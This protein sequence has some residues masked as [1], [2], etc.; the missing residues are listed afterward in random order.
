MASPNPLLQNIQ[1]GFR[2]LGSIIDRVLGQNG[3]FSY[4]TLL[5]SVVVLVLTTRFFTGWTSKSKS[6]SDGAPQ[7][8]PSLP[9]WVP[10]LGHLVNLLLS[11]DSLLKG[12]RDTSTRGIFALNLGGSTHNVI[13]SPSLSHSLLTQKSNVASH[14]PVAW[15]IL[16]R[17]FGM[18]LRQKPAYEELQP[19]L[20]ATINDHLLRD[21]YLAEM[22]NITMGNLRQNIPNLVSFVDSLVDQLPWER[23][24]N[25]TSI[26]NE[27]SGQYVEASLTPLLK[28][29][30]AHTA[31]P[32]LF[33]RAFVDNYPQLFDWL[34]AFDAGFLL[35]S[36]G[37]PRFIPYPGLTRAQIARSRLLDAM[38][39]FHRALDAYDTGKPA[40]DS[41]W[42]DMSDVS[43]LVR[44]R[45]AVYRKYNFPPY[46][47]AASDLALLWAMNANANPL[48]F[49]LVLRVYQDRDLLS[50]IQQEVA[51]YVRATQRPA[52]FGIPE[53]PEVTI[54][55]PGLTSKCP[56]LKACYIESLRVDSAPWSLKKVLQDFNLAESKADAGGSD[57]VTYRLKKGE[58]ADVAFD[59]HFT[60]PKFFPEPLEW[61]PDRHLKDLDGEG[62]YV[63]P[64]MGTIRPYGGGRGMCKGRVFAEK[65]CFAYAAAIFV[66]W[67]IEP[68][69]GERELKI[70]RH[71]KAT[72]VS[73]P[74]DDVR[75]RL[76]RREVGAKE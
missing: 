16:R 57:P 4:T 49:W 30:V 70:P 51:P 19:E 27:S 54:D 29:F 20:T 56:L 2:Y 37:A 71:G 66:L 53:P 55:V 72:A 24:S 48:I 62:R 23:V 60:D 22:V 69:G 21:P 9:Y 42:S 75:V 32:S 1:D 65:E 50:R 76:R 31:N 11:P 18:P 58:Y 39:S 7:Y 41:T 63:I 59:L 14:E 5:V 26:Q 3:F 43:P 38:V 46:S 35:L 52:T 68:A 8:V 28:N 13:F 25:V 6:I 15:Q 61:K 33:G 17:T 10:F 45:S 47:R 12:T 67:E 40:P 64:E 73:Y 44:A 74:R 36:T 34:W